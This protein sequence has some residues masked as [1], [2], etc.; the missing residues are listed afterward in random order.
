MQRYF[1]GDTDEAHPRMR[2]EVVS[3]TIADI[4]NF[5][6]AMAAVAARGRVVVANGARPSLLTPSPCHVSG[7]GGFASPASQHRATM[8]NAD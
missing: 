7:I 5:A 8:P 2:E 6:D 3:T 4:R 1:I